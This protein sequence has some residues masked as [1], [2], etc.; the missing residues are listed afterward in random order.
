MAVVDVV[1]SAA[2]VA[3]GRPAFVG[4]WRSSTTGLIWPTPPWS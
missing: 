3:V 1:G 2:V 4:S